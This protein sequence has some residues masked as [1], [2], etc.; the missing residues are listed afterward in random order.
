MLMRDSMVQ[1]PVEDGGGDYP[2][3]EDLSPGP[4]ALIAGQDHRPFL[5]AAADRAGRR[6]FAPTRSMG[7]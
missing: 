4:E 7:R 3:T 2:V 1:H 5:V 6:R